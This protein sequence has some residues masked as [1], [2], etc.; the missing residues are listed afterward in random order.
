MITLP[1]TE[2]LSHLRRFERDFTAAVKALQA[3]D[4][5]LTETLAMFRL[6]AMCD[7][8]ISTTN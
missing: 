8:A 1:E 5:N 2:N 7:D 6:R 3:T 4:A